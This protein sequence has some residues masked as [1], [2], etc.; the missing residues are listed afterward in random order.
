MTQHI[1]PNTCSNIS[2]NRTTTHYTQ[3]KRNELRQACDIHVASIL[4]LYQG[5]EISKYR[6]NK[7]LGLDIKFIDLILHILFWWRKS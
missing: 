3:L 6:F 7:L 4:D 5:K 1:F 2:C